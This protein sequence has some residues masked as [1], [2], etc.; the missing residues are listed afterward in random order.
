MMCT[1]DNCK[2]DCFSCANAFTDD[3]DKLRCVLKDGQF[4]NDDDSCEGW[5]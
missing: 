4:V 3:N 2:H 5:N 1:H